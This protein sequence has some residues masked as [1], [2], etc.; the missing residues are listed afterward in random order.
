MLPW[1]MFVKNL[2]MPYS[3]SYGVL[4]N[5]RVPLSYV[6]AAEGAGAKVAIP[7]S[8]QTDLPIGGQQHAACLLPG[9]KVTTT[10]YY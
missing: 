10:Y 8:E 7:L 5:C 1:Q 3:V 9:C 2:A 6:C 4:R